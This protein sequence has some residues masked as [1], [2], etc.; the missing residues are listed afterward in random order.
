MENV[1]VNST[2]GAGMLV[3]PNSSHEAMYAVTTLTPKYKTLNSSVDGGA[4]VPSQ[5]NHNPS[6]L[7]RRL[8]MAATSINLDL[9]FTNH[10]N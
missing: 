4:G 7:T 9:N 6:H 5:W 8:A 3:D 1:N 2:P 10:N